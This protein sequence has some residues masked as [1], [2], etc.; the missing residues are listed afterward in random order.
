MDASQAV[1]PTPD[2]LHTGWGSLFDDD[3]DD[4]AEYNPIA[5]EPGYESDRLSDIS[6]WDPV[7]VSEP[8]PLLPPIQLQQT[9]ALRERLGSV[10]KVDRV[11]QIL[12]FMESM[13]MNLPIF[14]DA[15]S[16][17][18]DECISDSKVRYAH[19]ALMVSEELP[20]I[21]ERWYK[22]PR[23]STSK[24]HNVRPQGARKV[25][26]K[27]ALDCVSEIVDRELEATAHIFRARTDCLSEEG[28]TSFQ[29]AEVVTRLCQETGA[30]N[31]F[32]L[33]HRAMH[34]CCR[35]TVDGKT[36]KNPDFVRQIGWC[37]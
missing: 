31:T 35:K 7:D 26:E 21:L 3:N 18:D 29:F 13:D 25:L 24:H 36:R 22:V 27:F 16:W 23:A 30:P 6:D 4:D 14:L 9:R 1:D 15:L 2:D 33:V 37:R 32:A 11:I 20:G 19:T 34:R 10:S 28:L 17:G 5:S 8:P 12:D